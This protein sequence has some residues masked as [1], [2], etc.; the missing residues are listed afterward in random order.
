MRSHSFK[1]ITDFKSDA[2]ELTRQV[3]QFE[4]NVATAITGLANVFQ[5]RF[6]VT[7]AKRANFAAHEGDIVPVSTATGNVRLLFPAA[8]TINAGQWIG[9]VQTDA[10]NVLTIAPVGGTIM[11]ASSYT[12]ATNVG[13]FLFVSAAGGWWKAI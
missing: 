12:V 7:D 9:V 8:T 6:R 5:V 11:G 1:T 4:T 2:D 10:S 3:A 13:L